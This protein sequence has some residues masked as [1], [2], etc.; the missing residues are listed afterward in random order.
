MDP[1]NIRPGEDS[2]KYLHPTIERYVGSVQISSARWCETSRFPIEHILLLPRSAS[3]FREKVHNINMYYVYATQGLRH[4]LGR[5]LTKC[6][7]M[8]S[9]LQ[10]HA[11]LLISR[12]P[13]SLVSN[14]HLFTR[15]MLHRST[16]I[17]D[18]LVRHLFALPDGGGNEWFDAAWE[19]T[20]AV[21]APVIAGVILWAITQ[22]VRRT[23]STVT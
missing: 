9:S 7:N 17:S 3:S 20:V 18:P 21:V 22:N 1:V 4:T 23:P 19:I 15:S 12:P 8:R 6:L 10:H 13:A 11:N 14:Y 5:I 16:I 2:P